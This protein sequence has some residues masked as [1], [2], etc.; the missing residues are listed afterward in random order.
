[1][2]PMVST[3]VMGLFSRSKT[4]T[5]TLRDEASEFL[6]LAH[7]ALDGVSPIADVRWREHVKV[8][9]RVR[10]MRIQPWA[11][12]V[13]SLELT[14]GDSTGGVTVVYFGRREIGGVKLGAHMVVEGRVSEAR[15]LL[16]ILNPSYQLLPHEVELPY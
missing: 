16:T 5:L 12:K 3:L 1:M 8:A 4:P 15:G 9:G 2:V 10:A 14:L 11:E 13:A 7:T 6:A